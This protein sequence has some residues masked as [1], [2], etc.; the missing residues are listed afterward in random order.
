MTVKCAPS[1]AGTRT[2]TMNVNSNDANI[3]TYNFALKAVA[4]SGT[5]TGK[6]GVKGNGKVIVDGDASPSTTD[7]TS[8][9]SA[10]VGNSITKTFVISNT[11]TGALSI[12]S[13]NFTGTNGSDFSLQNAPSFPLSIAANGTYSITVKFAPSAAGTRNATININSNDPTIATFNFALKATATAS[14]SLITVTGNGVNIV[15][16]D[17]TPSTTDFTHFGSIEENTTVSHD[18]VIKNVSSSDLYLGNVDH[19]GTGSAEFLVENAPEWP[20]VLA[21]GESVTIPIQFRPFDAGTYTASMNFYKEGEGTSFFSFTIKG[22]A[23]AKRSAPDGTGNDMTAIIEQDSVNTKLDYVAYPNPFTSS[24]KVRYD[25]AAG[26]QSAHIRIIDI[27]GRLVFEEDFS[28][29]SG[30]NEIEIGGDYLSHGIYY[31]TFK[32]GEQV[33]TKAIQK[34]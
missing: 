16:G 12:S 13:C 28:L 15:M 10:A 18:F 21:P 19:T 2:A 17:A 29:M 33:V 27:Q 30:N 8:M 4:S 26:N 1:A 5:S 7:N 3:G 32:V 14:T 25:N 23:T 9:G 22:V 20:V 31:L 24:F 6:I 34:L 11:G